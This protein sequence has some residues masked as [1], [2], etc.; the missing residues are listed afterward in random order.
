MEGGS[1]KDIGIWYSALLF[2]VL[3][4]YV[5][6]NNILFGMY[7]QSRSLDIIIMRL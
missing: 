5:K 2:K 1:E 3:E 4:C 6:Q 7:H